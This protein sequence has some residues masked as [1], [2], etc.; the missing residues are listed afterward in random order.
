VSSK[1]PRLTP[2]ARSLRG[3][4]AIATRYG[5]LEEA[6]ALRAKFRIARA[7]SW[8]RKLEDEHAQLTGRVEDG[9]VA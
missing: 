9:E 4:L 1:V 3:R 6:A 2:E 7:E 8:L 5:R